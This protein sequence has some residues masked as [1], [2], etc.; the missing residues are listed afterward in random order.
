ML[1]DLS[2]EMKK[3]IEEHILVEVP[4]IIVIKGIGIPSELESVIADIVDDNADFE[5]STVD[6]DGVWDDYEDRKKDY[7]EDLLNMT[8]RH[9]V[10]R[11]E[12]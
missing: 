4:C 8:T 10:D 5:D 3:R 11:G 2:E 7:L 9:I 6:W 1:P 12:W